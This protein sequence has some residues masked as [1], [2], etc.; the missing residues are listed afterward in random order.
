MVYE[1]NDSHGL[2]TS[3]PTYQASAL[4]LLDDL[5][6]PGS[7]GRAF[8]VAETAGVIAGVKPAAIVAPTLSFKDKRSVQQYRQVLKDLGLQSL[9]V[10]DTGG[11]NIVVSRDK[12][13]LKELKSA[14]EVV[15]KLF[16][17]SI[18]AGANEHG[19]FQISD[20]H[21]K[22]IGRLLGYP[23]TATEYFIRRMRTMSTP[24]E[25]PIIESKLTDNRRFF[26]NF[27]LSPDH[28]DDEVRA[29]ITPFEQAVHELTPKTYVRIV[30]EGI[31]LEQLDGDVQI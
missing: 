24:G 17:D 13:V 7:I 4:T 5:G 2:H 9:P 26:E 23:P 3:R 30:A 20:E 19:G 12:A 16:Q 1:A 11:W 29:Y 15:D 28:Y 21:E 25:L 8:D 27:I 31:Q 14:L 10:R 22:T 6:I 18:A